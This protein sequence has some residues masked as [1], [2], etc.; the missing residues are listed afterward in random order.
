MV[1]PPLGADELLL[2]LDERS[3]KLE[4]FSAVF[5]S[6]QISVELGLPSN[7]VRILW[8]DSPGEDICAVKN[9]RGSI[10]GV[11]VEA[12]ATATRSRRK[13]EIA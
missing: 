9:R 1:H 5:S 11:R 4:G 7:S 12:Y 2:R 10:S 6:N 3:R 8:G 13:A